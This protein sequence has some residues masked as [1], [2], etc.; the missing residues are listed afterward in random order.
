[1]NSQF[2][3]AFS[4][5]TGL[6]LNRDES[7]EHLSIWRSKGEVYRHGIMKV[8]EFDPLAVLPAMV[9]ETFPAAALGFIEKLSHRFSPNEEDSKEIEAEKLEIQKDFHLNPDL[10]AIDLHDRE[11]RLHE[12]EDTHPIEPRKLS[13]VLNA[14][15]WCDEEGLGFRLFVYDR[16]GYS[17]REIDLP[18]LAF[19]DYAEGDELFAWAIP[20]NK[21]RSLNLL[22]VPI[23][24]EEKNNE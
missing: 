14:Y 21:A 16:Y 22:D 4:S 10:F 2:H 7:A 11:I 3:R 23:I 20:A 24:G 19:T 17:R 13:K 6:H 9:K 1:M 5:R 12:I 18:M 15:G 8:R